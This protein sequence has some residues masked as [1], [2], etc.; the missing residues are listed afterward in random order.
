ML[1]NK[2]ADI[3]ISVVRTVLVHI[4]CSE[5]TL[6]RQYP[7]ISDSVYANSQTLDIGNA[8]CL[9]LQYPLFLEKYFVFL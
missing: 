4:V 9:I 8:C 6:L 3:S 1:Q 2:A 7:P 5:R